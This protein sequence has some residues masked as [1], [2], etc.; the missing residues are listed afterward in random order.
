MP[1]SPRLNSPFSI[2]PSKNI[3]FA[4]SYF[5]PFYSALFYLAFVFFLISP[6][7]VLPLLHLAF[8]QVAFSIIAFVSIC[9]RL[10]SP[11]SISPCPNL[12]FV[13]I[14][15]HPISPLPASPLSSRLTWSTTS[16]WNCASLPQAY[17]VGKSVRVAVCTDAAVALRIGKHLSILEHQVTI[18]NK[19]MRKGFILNV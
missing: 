4:F 9:L 7:A 1:I 14:R 16:L 2:P 6:F 10:N 17:T 8:S 12:H 13:L 18:R 15:L 19:I 5:A 11:P 3:H